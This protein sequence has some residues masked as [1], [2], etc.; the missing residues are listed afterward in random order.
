MS[1]GKVLVLGGSRI[2][3]QHL[4]ARLIARLGPGQVVATYCDS[5]FAGGVRF[6]SLTM[7]LSEIGVNLKDISHAVIL[8]GNINVD[9]CARHPESS[10]ALNV[11]S[12]IN[13]IDQLEEFGICPVFASSEVVFD[14]IKGGY[15][16]NDSVNP[17]LLY[18]K[19]KVEIEVY[20]DRLISPALIVRIAHVYGSD[21]AGGGVIAG[22]YRMVASG[23]ETV[24]CASDYIASP[25]H[26]EDVAK[27][28]DTLMKSGRHGIYHLAGPQPMSRKEIF[29]TMLEE[30]NKNEP[31]DV[32]V[33]SCSIDDFST[34]ERRPHD[35]SMR[36]DKLVVETGIELRDLRSACR[37]LVATAGQAAT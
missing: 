13:I 20:I 5:P 24:H 4:C 29:E 11:T 21:P 12:V 34:E 36:P 37:H 3:G 19:Q 27:A 16:E 32:A 6:D 23:E 10:R 28:M 31:V 22:W 2:I 15:V 35:V 18:G 8:V 17:I 26:V 9:E 1:D 33:E 25:I 7:R 14:G 30:M